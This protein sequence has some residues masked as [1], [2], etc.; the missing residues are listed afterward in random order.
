[1][2][3]LDTAVACL[4]S[5]LILIVVVG[6][7]RGRRRLRES[8]FARARRQF[9]NR[10]E[11]LEAKFFDMASNQSR[12]RGLDWSRCDFDDDVFYARDRTSGG[13]SALV[14]VTVGF[15]AREG[16]GMEDVPAVGN[17]RAAT[18]LFH[19]SSGQWMT[20]GRAIFNLSPLEA[21]DRFHEKL[22]LIAQEYGGV[23]RGPTARAAADREV[24]RAD[25]NPGR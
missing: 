9:H 13:I 25:G 22:E 10:R 24:R 11:Y 12:P 1:M 15:T 7:A 14:A 20:Q 2:S 4:A 3:W 17:L 19:Y 23:A 16:G 18:A 5:A 8:V 6:V 21:I